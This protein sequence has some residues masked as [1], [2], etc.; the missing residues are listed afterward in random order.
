[1]KI[2]N[3]SMKINRTLFWLLFVVLLQGALD[4]DG[5]GLQLEGLL[6]PEVLVMAVPG[7]K[8]RGHVAEQIERSYDHSAP[9]SEQHIQTRD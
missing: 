7:Q 1:M 3:P 5:H 8:V 4:F 6:F 9:I 2:L